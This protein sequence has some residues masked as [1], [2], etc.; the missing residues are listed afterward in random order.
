MKRNM[1][2]A[3]F[4]AAGLIGCGAPVE[5]QQDGQQPVTPPTAEITPAPEATEAPDTLGE[6]E[7]EIIG[8]AYAG[9]NQFPYQ[10]RLLVNGSHWCG[11]TIVNANWIVT[12]AHCVYGVNYQTIVVVAGDN[13][14]N[15]YEATEQSRTIAGYAYH[16][17]FGYS[18]GAPVHDVAVILLSSPLSLNYAVQPL[19]L[20][21]DAAPYTYLTASGWGQTYQGS[22]QSNN[23]KYANLPNNPVS[24]CNGYLARNLY[25][26][27]ELCVG[28][29][30][31]V[32][33]GC[34]GDSGGP[35]AGSG[36]LRGIVSW[37]RGTTC[38]SYTVF[39]DVVTY[40]PWIRSYTG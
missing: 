8:G 38:N 34:H 36:V 19:A 25:A 18:A 28:Y 39:T 24:Y 11:G 10:V 31:G 27:Y 37:G 9:Q 7:Q 14:L 21:G 6:A 17:S 12:A 23:L 16:P 20:P 15:T 30:N 32:E 40:V 4:I 3:G 33:G 13:I 1:L 22:P 35:L 5:P 26:G 29:Y 2:F